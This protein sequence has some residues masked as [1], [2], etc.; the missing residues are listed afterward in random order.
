L[1]FHWQEQKKS[2]CLQPW[3]QLENDAN[4]KEAIVVH[5]EYNVIGSFT[6][7]LTTPTYDYESIYDTNL[8]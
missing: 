1:I 6:H 3:V 4:K 8:F 5:Q 2:V 7:L